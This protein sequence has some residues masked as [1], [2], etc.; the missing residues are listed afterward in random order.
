M[1][2]FGTHLCDGT[3][4][5]GRWGL[6]SGLGRS[7]VAAVAVL[8]VAALQTGISLSTLRLLSLQCITGS[9]TTEACTL[10]FAPVP[11]D[12]HQPQHSMAA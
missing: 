8:P 12:W 4:E 10:L 2:S 6:S 11:A 1:S 5:L 3:D 9:K 7:L